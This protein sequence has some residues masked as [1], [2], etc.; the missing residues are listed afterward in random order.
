MGAFV[1]ANNTDREHDRKFQKALERAEELDRVKAQVRREPV[2][3]P[4]STTM[5]S[6]HFKVEPGGWQISDFS[7]AEDNLRDAALVGRFQA[8]GGSGNDIEVVVSNYDAALNWANGHSARVLYA[9]PGRLT[10][11][12][13]N[14][15]IREAGRYAVALSNRF[16]AVTSKTVFVELRLVYKTVDVSPDLVDENRQ[17]WQQWRVDPFPEPTGL[18]TKF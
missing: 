3:R 17:K 7:V 11:G 12:E 8:Y 2:L 6:S 13:F 10:T 5:V 16:S 14:V 15:P 18:G 4:V 9:T 1:T